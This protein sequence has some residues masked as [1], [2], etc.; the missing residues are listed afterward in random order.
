MISVER[1]KF[2]VMD[3]D[4]TLTDGK[5]H[6]GNNGELFKSF[7]VKDGYAIKE[8]ISKLN[9]LPIVITA[10]TSS[11]LVHRCNELN[12]KEIHQGVRN[13]LFELKK[14]LK[15]YS[16]KDNI[17]YSLSNVAFVGDD[18][19]D[20]QCIHPIKEMG[21]ITACP[22]DAAKKVFDVADFICS[23]NAGEGA[24]R[25][26]VDWLLN[27]R[28]KSSNG[29]DKIRKISQVAFDYIK[30]FSLSNTQDGV[31]KLD[32]STVVKVMTY[33]TKKIENTCFESHKKNIDIQY[34]IYGCES[35]LVADTN[36]IKKENII[37]YD[38]SNDTVLYNHNYG[39]NILI[40]PGDS[41]ILYPNDA[42]R[43]S[44]AINSSNKVRK[45]VFK[46]LID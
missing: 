32:N 10:R 8:I 22:N 6:I 20:L 36:K 12:I 1:I 2:L 3:V 5:I 14:I 27:T 44:I 33:N 41:V 46:I 16:E 19:L 42:H 37:E 9:I 29:L 28:L 11:I 18:E 4:G 31:Y 40:Y 17:E 35:M 45:L 7:N 13:K 23:K 15:V 38:E 25:E 43:G 21:G 30:N 24:V 39:E 26:F 34:V